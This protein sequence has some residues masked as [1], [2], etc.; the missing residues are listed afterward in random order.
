MRAFTHQ[1]AGVRLHTLLMQPVE[2]H[3][4]DAVNV[5]RFV[6]YTR[7]QI[8]PQAPDFTAKKKKKTTSTFTAKS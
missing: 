8:Q 2:L 1:R 4:T 7:H 3:G 5:D 6:R